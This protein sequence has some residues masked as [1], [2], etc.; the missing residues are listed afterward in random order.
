[1][2]S[3]AFPT[4]AGSAFGW[5]GDGGVRDLA[6]G[7]GLLRQ[8]CTEAVHWGCAA[9]A[10]AH[11]DGV[12][13]DRD[14]VAAAGLRA[15]SCRK[16]GYSESICRDVPYRPER[17]TARV[18]RGAPG[19]G[20]RPGDTCELVVSGLHEGPLCRG[21][22]ACGGVGLYGSEAGPSWIVCDIGADG[23]L[24]RMLDEHEGDG[25]GTIDVDIDAGRI[26]HEADGEVLELSISGHRFGR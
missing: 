23:Q 26:R 3:Y 24:V 22:F 17:F 14:P 20:P 1:M 16:L 7:I 19:V 5:E 12:G 11:E 18:T 9:L 21:Y 13:V 6:R 2:R 10:R 25:D 15:Q 4:T 8:T